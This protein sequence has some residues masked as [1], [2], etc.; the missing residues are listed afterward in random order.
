MNHDR[1][2]IY[3]D[4]S[5]N[6]FTWNGWTYYKTPSGKTKKRNATKIESVGAVDYAALKAKF[7]YQTGI[8]LED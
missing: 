7:E 8:R 1:V 5:K 4:V 2:V 6:T 3:G